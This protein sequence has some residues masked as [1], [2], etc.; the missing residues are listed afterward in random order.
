MATHILHTTCKPAGMEIQR[1]FPAVGSYISRH[2]DYLCVRE[3]GDV[4]N[5]LGPNQA[6]NTLAT[7]TFVDA[8]LPTSSGTFGFIIRAVGRHLAHRLVGAGRGEE[9]EVVRHCQHRRVDH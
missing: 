5:F 1:E 2:K 9:C 6:S 8:F 3:A 4:F 7:D